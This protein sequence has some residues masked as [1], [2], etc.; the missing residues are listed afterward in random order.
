[1]GHAAGG[2]ADIRDIAAAA[3]V[4]PT[5]VSHAISGARPVK[6]ST[7]ERIL[8]IASSMAYQPSRAATSLQS[9]RTGVIGFVSDRISSTPHAGKVLLGVQERARQRGEILVIVETQADPEL[10]R[11][12]LTTLLAGGVDGVI[13][14]RM[15][16]ETIVVPEQLHAIST[17][18]VNA[19]A[20]DQAYTS[21]VPDESQIARVALRHLQGF[22]HTRIAMASTIDDTPARAGRERQWGIET[23]GTDS[24]LVRVAST[25]Q[26]GRQA[27]AEL[28]SRAEIPT[29]IFCFNDQIAMGIYQGAATRGLRIPEDLSVVGVDDLE[30]IASAL[31]PG[32]TTVALP[33]FQMGSWAMSRLAGELDDD[34]ANRTY[35]ELPCELVVRN[36]AALPRP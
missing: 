26:G 31:D 17:V 4:S 36:S 22:G 27:A 19:V 2:R 28:L 32:L 11:Q 6:A 34:Q 30:I 7:R 5:T 8:R 33:H 25:A 21:V 1:M 18:L 12:Q 24:D 3:G 35:E 20:L 10:E 14:A 29:A 23:G 16:H 15:S 9:G 13:Y